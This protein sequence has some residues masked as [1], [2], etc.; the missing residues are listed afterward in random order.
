MSKGWRTVADVTLAPPLRFQSETGR[1]WWKM[2]LYLDFPR[3]AP[4]WMDDEEISEVV[5]DTWEH[6]NPVLFSIDK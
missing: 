5:N 1:R 2:A 3:H 4:E 6:D